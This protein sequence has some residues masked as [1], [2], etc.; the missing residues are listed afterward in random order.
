MPKGCTGKPGKKRSVIVKGKIKL[1]P[2]GN[3][4]KVNIT[5]KRELKGVLRT[6]PKLK[7]C[8]S[9][10]G[11]KQRASLNITGALDDTP[12]NWRTVDFFAERDI[13]PDAKT[14]FTATVDLPGLKNVPLTGAPLFSW[15]NT[16]T[17]NSQDREP[18]GI[19]AE[20]IE[21]TQQLFD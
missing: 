7:S 15:F 21:T 12:D 2:E 6:E 9:E 3:L 5:K 17:Y 14:S 8:G 19:L 1:R 16:W 13:V 11:G 20:R 10:G 18:I 4:S